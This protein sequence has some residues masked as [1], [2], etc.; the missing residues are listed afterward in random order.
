MAFLLERDTISGKEGKAFLTQNGKNVEL[1]G[2]KK[3]QTTADIQST[4][5]TVVG[6]RKIQSKPTGVKQEGTGTVY[7]GTPLFV[8]MALQYA[9]TGVMPYFDIQITNNDP[10]TTVG[11]QV[12][13]YYGCKLT[14]QIPLSILDSDTD[15]LTF[16][17][18]FTYSSVAML[19][20]FHDPAQL[21]S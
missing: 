14:G 2:I 13:A 11:E 4:D 21:G 20:S 19:Q 15:M 16:D 12:M 7:Y 6:T 5:M 17:I 8:E 3:I 18:S 1:F 9:N 10:T